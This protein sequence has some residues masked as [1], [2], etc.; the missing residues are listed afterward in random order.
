MV[1]LL[2]S[3]IR[4]HY[5][6]LPYPNFRPNDIILYNLDI[7]ISLKFVVG[8]FS[9]CKI[10]MTC[11]T[12]M[13]V[14]FQANPADVHFQLKEFFSFKSTLNRLFIVKIMLGL[15]Q[16]VLLFNHAWLSARIWF[17]Y[18]D[19]IRV[20]CYTCILRQNI[21][22]SYK[23]TMLSSSIIPWRPD[24]GRFTAVQLAMRCPENVSYGT[25]S[26]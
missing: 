21:V 11:C 26:I 8:I 2:H 25:Y 17:L 22:A 13:T 12:K 20:V 15:F 19:M 3:R 1:I 18:F 10:M 4:I 7:Q 16:R 5:R 14:I 9:G 24:S 6:Q 23:N